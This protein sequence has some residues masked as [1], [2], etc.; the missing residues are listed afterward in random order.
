MD[1]KKVVLITGATSGIGLAVAKHLWRLG[2]S[3]AIGCYVTTE[4]GYEELR[5][6]ERRSANKQ[7]RMLFITLDVSDEKSIEAA[8]ETVQR[9]LRDNQMKLYA[10]INNAGLGSLV[11]YAWLPKRDVKKLVETN[12]LGAMLMTREFL[13]LLVQSGGRIVNVSSGLGL[14]PGQTYATY[15]VTKTGLIYFTK[16]LNSELKQQ[17][18]VTSV[19]VLP[20]NFI[21][22]TK[23][24][25]QINRQHK[26]GWQTLKEI[27]RSL[28][29]KEYEKH[30]ELLTS[31]DR[32]M[33][34]AEQ[35]KKSAGKRAQANSS[36]FIVKSVINPARELLQ[37]L[38]GQNVA[39]SLE[40]SGILESFEDA[41]RLQEPPELIFGGDN[42]YNLLVGSFL[43]TVPTSCINLLG[44]SVSRSLYQ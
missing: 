10:L 16:A 42:M 22:N 26:E 34:R 23:I 25:A 36:N 33:A 9:H 8:Y 44:A 11:P 32:V 37:V 3:L 12:L 27:E 41:L 43:L 13:P 39:E 20:H 4:P 40:Q 28:Y 31:L 2:Y 19:A 6:L 1:G 29:R 14:L 15:G 18:N 38:N 17:F 21:K 30:S 5:D 7:Q 35:Q 24:G